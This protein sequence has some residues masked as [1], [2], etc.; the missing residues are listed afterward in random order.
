LLF[1]FAVAVAVAVAFWLSS[2]A[3]GGGSASAS[4]LQLLAFWLSSRRDLLLPLPVLKSVS[5]VPI[6]VKPALHGHRNQDLH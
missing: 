6:R 2:F 5:S 4:L 1:A 3:E